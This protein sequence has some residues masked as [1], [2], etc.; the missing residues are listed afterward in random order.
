MK[1]M[2]KAIPFS[3]DTTLSK[4]ITATD[5]TIYV[6]NPSLL[7]DAP[8]YA[9]IGTIED[10]AETILYTGK[11]SNSLTGCKRGL[12]GK[13]IAWASGELIARNYTNKDH[14]NFID[15]INELNDLAIHNLKDG[16]GYLNTKNKTCEAKS[17][18]SLVIGSY[19]TDSFNSAARKW[20]V[21][22]CKDL[23]ATTHRFQFSCT[24]IDFAGGLS[25]G[26]T[27]YLFDSSGNLMGEATADNLSS[28]TSVFN[29][30]QSFMSQLL[31]TAF[32]SN[33]SILPHYLDNSIIT[34][35]YNKVVA[36]SNFIIGNGTSSSNRANAFRV[37][38]RGNTYGL[39]AFQST[40]ADYAEYYEWNDENKKN[41][42][43]VG[44]F[45]TFAKGS[46]IRIANVDDNYILGVV[47]GNP[48]VIGNS[49]ND[50][51]SNMYLK[52]PFD[53]IIYEEVD[54]KI[55]PKINPEYDPTK[56][57]I[58]R[59]KRPEWATIGTHGQLS[60]YDDGS[61]QVDGYCKAGDNGVA[62]SAKKGVNT[63]RVIGRLTDN[64]IK[65]QIK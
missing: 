59:A 19:N 28:M 17:L 10:T 61:C 21:S 34:G 7:P 24:L 56:S 18:A 55:Q 40:G 26:D 39:S 22:N 63:Y 14:E 60:V 62:T 8:N 33:S 25:V 53:R 4:T 47:S 49:Y 44:R 15:N 57:F 46:K 35:E 30:P 64:I 5:T 38:K 43:R 6:T 58:G 52:D 37:D 41:E 50:Q 3:P 9:T 13:A 45:V 23:Y 65:I 20:K 2:Y 29:Y 16:N 36:D 31:Y 51:W 11:T 27:A 1:Q 54:G 32:I 12:E 48:S 42:D